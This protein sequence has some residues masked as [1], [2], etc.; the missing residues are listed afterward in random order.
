MSTK[1]TNS[2][3]YKDKINNGGHFVA[4]ATDDKSWGLMVC[5]K[6]V[7]YNGFEIIKNMVSKN[8]GQEKS[9]KN[10]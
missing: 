7:I 1:L 6:K 2:L 5:F 9:G 8:D 10:K 4:L 3:N